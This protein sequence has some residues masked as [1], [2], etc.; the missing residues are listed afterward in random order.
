MYGNQVEPIAEL[1]GSGQVV[2]RFVYGGG[3]HVPEYMIRNGMLYRYVVDHLGSVLAVV[4]A[5][6]GVVAQQMSYDSWGRVLGDTNPGFQPFVFAGGLWD[7][8]TGLV[9]F[10]ARDYDPELG[11]W[12]AKDPIGFEGGQATLYIYVGM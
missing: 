3:G 10:G 5:N 4:D 7:R 2:S 9:R 1:D 8:E 11:R 12:T 6:T